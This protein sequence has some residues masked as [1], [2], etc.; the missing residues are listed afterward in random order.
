MNQ[1]SSKEKHPNPEAV[2]VSHYLGLPEN[3][4]IPKTRTS[5]HLITAPGLLDD[6]RET[7]CLSLLYSKGSSSPQQS[8]EN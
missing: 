2:G 5:L 6:N 4:P 1:G 7:G 3:V 8:P